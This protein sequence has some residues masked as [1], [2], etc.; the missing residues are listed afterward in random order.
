MP[1]PEDPD[2]SHET[3]A[4]RMRVV[5]LHDP[6]GLLAE[7]ERRPGAITTHFCPVAD[8]RRGT[9]AGYEVLLGVG[10]REPTGPRTLSQ[11]VHS[12]AAGRLEAHLVR[13]ALAER[14]RLPEHAFL[15]IN[16]STPALRSVE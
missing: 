4:H 13:R 12:Q 5:D 1:T 7:V 15:M 3:Q 16:V 6:T 14:E 11:Q 9:A 2:S 10:S 8:L